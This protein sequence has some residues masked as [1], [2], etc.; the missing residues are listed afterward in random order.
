MTGLAATADLLN[1]VFAPDPPLQPDELS[2]YYAQNPEGHAAVGR[3]VD[4]GRQLGNYALVPLRFD[5]ADGAIV[6]LGLGVDLAGH[7]DARGSGAFRRTGEDSYV[8][9]RSA[10]LD[11]ALRAHMFGAQIRSRTPR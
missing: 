2:W 3:V 7:P 9:G 1:E 11:G 6:R 4:G 5:G 10:G 8:E